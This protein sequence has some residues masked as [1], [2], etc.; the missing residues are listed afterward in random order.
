ML[1]KCIG[2]LTGD[3]VNEEGRNLPLEMFVLTD[4]YP[5]PH[6]V[7]IE[8]KILNFLF[9]GDD[10]YLVHLITHSTNFDNLKI[11]DHHFHNS[12]LDLSNSYITRD[13]FLIHHNNIIYPKNYGEFD[14]HQLLIDFEY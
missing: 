10:F 9:P 4:N 14:I 12:I 13:R 6:F 3:V 2:P 7:V 11:E 5:R 8:D 1:Y